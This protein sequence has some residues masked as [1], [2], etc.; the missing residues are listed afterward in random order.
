[1]DVTPWINTVNQKALDI[2]EQFSGQP[3]IH[4]QEWLTYDHLMPENAPLTFQITPKTKLVHC[5][6]PLGDR[7][8]QRFSDVQD[9]A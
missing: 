6:P 3:A 9:L 5:I 4:W 8:C 1:L 7:C 2:G